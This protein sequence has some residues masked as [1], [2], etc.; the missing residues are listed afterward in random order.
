MNLTFFIALVLLAQQAS[1][2]P[3]P[4]KRSSNS[5]V[6]DNGK[7][8][9]TVDLKT[10]RFSVV[11]GSHASVP[12]AIGAI[13]LRDGRE[14]KTSDYAEHLCENK[15]VVR[16]K[17]GFGE[18][19]RITVHHRQSGEPELN[20]IFTVYAN[21][22]EA[23]VQLIAQ[24]AEEIASNHIAPIV[25]ETGGAGVN[26]EAGDPLQVLFVPFDNDMFVRYNSQNWGPEAE[27]YEATA[28]YDNTSRSGLVLG[29][30]DHDLWKT[31]IALRNRQ[32]RQI[33][34]L[35]VYGG[36]TGYWTHDK[37]PH[38]IVSGR[39]IRSPRIFLGWFPDWRDGME[40]FGKAN[41]LIKPAL[42]WKY[43]VPFGWNSWAAHKTTL[44]AAHANAATDFLS[45]P[46][47]AKDF[48]STGPTF[49]NLDA[50]WDFIKE[51]DMVAFVKRAHSL[52]LNAGVYWTPFT[53]WD[54]NLDRKVEGTNDKY[55]YRDLTIKDSQGNPLPKVDGGWPLDPT[56]PGTQ[57][58]N[59]YRY[60]QFIQW[61]F[62]YVKLD[63]MSHGTF[64][65][66]HFD[67]SVTTGIAAYN[68]GMKQ[69]VETFDEKKIGRPFFISLSIAP[70]F[71]HGYAHSRR[72]SCDAFANI[73]HTEYMLNSLNYGWWEHNTLYRYNDPDH[74]VVY[75]THG[76][77]VVTFAEG[78]SRFIASVITGGMLLNGDDLT[79]SAARERVRQLF[80]KANVLA[81][82]RKSRT[83]RPVEADTG[84][85]ATDAYTLYDPNEK[86]LYVA[87]F[88]FNGKEKATKRL[89]FS[90]LGLDSAARYRVQS[91]W[92]TWSGAF[93]GTLSVDLEPADCTLLR[94]Q[95]E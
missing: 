45:D 53:A 7:V 65:G 41:A 16:V 5:L 61:G 31:G 50:F 67:K 28:I 93:V 33:G 39:A 29:S 84:A 82:A 91:L 25:V 81:L 2:L 13:R 86:A 64:E 88:N 70:L 34:G 51:E 89:T 55:I 92:D 44:N 87:V 36:A 57:Q 48:H 46:T 15:D 17:D 63:F 32:P 18:G 73:G 27:S 43:G 10:G 1:P 26:L 83:F 80:T 54:D 14:R 35:R 60:A 42:E 11:W 66:S 24:G 20:H 6:V 12:G 68:F 23:Y 3:F 30:I 76:E 69:I 49:V 95:R 78:K 56:H 4:V 71:P 79:D 21:R 58:R 9:V 59:A 72:I 37:E 74:T 8:A 90:R 19:V 94:F 52:G 38:G 75:R 47:I 77:G 62:D 22:P 85:A 40:Q